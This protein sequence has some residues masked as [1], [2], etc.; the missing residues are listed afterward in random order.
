MLLPDKSFVKRFRDI[1]GARGLAKVL[2]HWDAKKFGSRTGTD[3]NIFGSP[4]G[5]RN[6][7]SGGMC[8]LPARADRERFWLLNK[9]VETS[10]L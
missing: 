5:E 4:R 7:K 1:P 3:R 6:Q 2:G 10:D 9:S 8:F